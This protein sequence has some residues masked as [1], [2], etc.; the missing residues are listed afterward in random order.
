MPFEL[1]ELD[2]S[3][4][5]AVPSQTAVG[6]TFANGKLLFERSLRPKIVSNRPRSVD[7]SSSG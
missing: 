7:S 5:T 3:H 4:F 1:R 2:D 6:F